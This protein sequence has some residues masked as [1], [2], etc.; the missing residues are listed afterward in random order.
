MANSTVRNININING[1]EVVNS[2]NGITKAMRETNR[3]LRNLNK[4]DADYTEQLKK[5][6][7][8]IEQLKVHQKAFKEE[9]YDTTEAVKESTKELNASSF[10]MQNFIGALTSGD[11]EGVR[12]EF[13]NLGNGIG[14]V[15]KQAIAF[16]A[17]PIGAT[18]AVV[19]KYWYD[20]NTEMEKSL[21][22]TKQFTGLAGDELEAVGVKVNG[23]VERTGA[24]QKEVLTAVQALVKDFGLSYDEAFNQINLGYERAGASAEDFFDNTAEYSSFL[25]QAGY[26]ADEFFAIM[27]SGAEN[28]VYKDKILDSIKEVDLRLKEMPNSASESL[29]NAFGQKFTDTISNGVRTG[30]LNTK[31]ALEMISNEAERTGLNLQQKGQLI[32]D[33]FG[34]AGEDAGG[35]EKVIASINSGLDKAG[36]GLTELEQAQMESVAAQDEM[37]QAFADL[38]HSTDGGFS[39]MKAQLM[40]GVYKGITAIVNGVIGAYNGFVNLYNS[41]SA[42]AGTMNTIGAVGKLVF[43]ALSN[44]IK[45]IGEGFRGLVSIVG[46]IFKGDFSAIPDIW[47]NTMNS[48]KEN[49]VSAAKESAKNFVDAWNGE[50]LKLKTI[51]RNVVDNV[52]TTNTSTTLSTDNTSKSVDTKAQKELE[53]EQKKQEKLKELFEKGEAEIDEILLRSREQR[54]NARL[55][56]I[57]REEAEITNKYAKEI[58]KYKGHTERIKELEAARDAEI[59]EAR[60]VRAE[61]Y[62]LEAEAIEQQNEITK[63]ENEFERQAEQAR[64]AEERALIMIEKTREIALM[65]LA[66]EQEM[67]L[68]RVENVE[69][70]ESLI[71]AIKE[72]YALQAGRINADAARAQEQ[73]EKQKVEW[74]NLSEQARL[75]IIKDVFSQT[76]EAFNEGTGAWKAAKIAETTV[77]TYQAAQ[78]AEASASLIPGI[79]YILGP[80]MAGIAVVS[81]LKKVQKIAQTPIAKMPTHFYGGYT[82]D[83]TG[84]FGGDEY[85]AFTGYVHANEWVS[86]AVMT[87]SPRYAPIINWLDNERQMMLNGGS[88]G[89]SN[90][91]IDPTVLVALATSVNQL[92]A[93]LENGIEART[94]FGYEDV[95]KMQ[96]L[97]KELNQTKQN[98]IISNGN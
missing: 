53:R 32:A 27:Q 71:L 21:K 11:L 85:G 88:S 77:A 60:R 54:E 30:S 51:E 44:G 55:Q 96:N 49:T 14:S 4:N 12:D 84:N 91:F 25:A 39:V 63:R 36:A 89:N 16:I 52:S 93:V 66:V 33:V 81:G 86:P 75:N 94:R 15:T 47:K 29:T 41:S 31:Q 13:K 1:K 83:G 57:A 59:A 26:S 92:N 35:F 79:G 37:N 24:S 50:N 28:G 3:D 56:G 17:T 6:Q 73:I 80:I 64:S 10:S 2:L 65:Q 98:A 72:K 70:S 62:R 38:F 76:A 87:Q 58:E 48:I 34:S 19:T 9:I 22:V 68:A 90:P 61:Q 45:N 74:T 20:Y 23:I 42:F 40:E 69:G 82:G 8:T 43:N 78:N 5:H 18:I 67:E 46:A 97:Q 95:E 7:D